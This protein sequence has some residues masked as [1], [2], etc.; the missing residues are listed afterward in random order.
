M[1]TQTIL[2]LDGIHVVA[3]AYVHLGAA[4]GEMEIAAG[5]E[6]SE[7]SGEEPTVGVDRGSG[8]FGLTPIAAH[9]RPTAQAH[10]AHLGV[11]VMSAI[12]DTTKSFVES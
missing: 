7:I 4:T 11:A 9:D 1:L 10:G 8:E 5:I 3:T 12:D 2:D 6:E